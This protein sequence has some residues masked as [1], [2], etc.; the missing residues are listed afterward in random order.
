M[1][2]PIEPCELALAVL[3]SDSVLR[4]LLGERLSHGYGFSRTS[5]P[6]AY[7]DAGVLKLSATVRQAPDPPAETHGLYTRLV[8]VAVGADQ[9]DSTTHLTVQY[10][11]TRIRTVLAGDGIG[12]VSPMFRSAD[13]RQFDGRP[14][15]QLDFQYLGGG[16]LDIRLE[17]PSEYT[18]MLFGCGTLH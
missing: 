16:P 17:F 10:A 8:E 1:S 12:V 2:Y 11:A 14:P 13:H 5:V 3:A 4:E 6:S 7:D 9:T 15:L 18:S